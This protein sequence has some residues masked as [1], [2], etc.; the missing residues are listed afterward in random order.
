M[1]NSAEGFEVTLGWESPEIQVHAHS[2]SEHTHSNNDVVLA[3]KIIS[4]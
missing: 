2:N 3:L 1:A 4:Y